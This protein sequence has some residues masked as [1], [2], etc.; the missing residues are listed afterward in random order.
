MNTNTYII[1]ISNFGSVKI[2]IIYN[3]NHSITKE[4]EQLQRLKFGLR[5]FWFM[6]IIIIEI[7][8]QNNFQNFVINWQRNDVSQKLLQA[9]PWPVVEARMITANWGR[10]YLYSS[11]HVCGYMCTLSISLNQMWTITNKSNNFYNVIINQQLMK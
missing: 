7:K 4:K 10:S 11:L 9:P 3:I 6:L 5:V 8:L 2:A 1:I